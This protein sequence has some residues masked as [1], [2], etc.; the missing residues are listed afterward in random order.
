MLLSL[1]GPEPPA[2]GGFNSFD[3]G[4]G[5][6]RAAY[7]VLE[8]L[9]Y[10]VTRSRV[11]AGGAVRWVFRPDAKTKPDALDAWVRDGGRV[12]LADPEGEFAARLGLRVRRAV[13]DDGANLVSVS[14]VEGVSKLSLGDAH[15][16]PLDATG[17]RWGMAGGSPLVTIHSHGRGDV[18]LLHRPGVFT[19]AA[20]RRAG[21]AVLLCR[22]ADAMLDGRRGE[23]AFD[24]F[25]HGLRDRPG[26]AE[27]LLRPPT[28]YVTLAGLAFTAVLVWHHAPRF[29]QT[30]L[31][32]PPRRRSKEEFL[33]AMADLLD[34]K[35]DYRD[36][37][38]TVRRRVVHEIETE[39]GLP[40]GVPLPALL[41]EAGRRRPGSADTL[42]HALREGALPARASRQAFVSALNDLETAYDDFSQRRTPR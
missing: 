16:E 20:L 13:G 29:G 9:D 37:F 10:P 6:F 39:L 11:P 30:A 2:P 38:D 32:R 21:N 7:L 23:V 24:E 27:L 34:R 17:R 26:V 8:A 5:G 25:V 22:L 42:R 40:A 28:L 36:A 19:N 1:I 18:W 31:D 15:V 3:A 41:D 12:L 35:G 33:D 14:G 4:P